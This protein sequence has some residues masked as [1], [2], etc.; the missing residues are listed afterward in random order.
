MYNK[1]TLYEGKTLGTSGHH[2]MIEVTKWTV[3]ELIYKAV[4]IAL[5]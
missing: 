2:C 3:T 4:D 1:Q 5:F